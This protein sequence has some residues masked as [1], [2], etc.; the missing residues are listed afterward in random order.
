VHDV[1]SESRYRPPE[2]KDC[3]EKVKRTTTL[4]DPYML[5]SELC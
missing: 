4:I 2:L 1:R 3:L 5:D